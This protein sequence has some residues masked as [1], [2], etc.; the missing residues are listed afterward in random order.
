MMWA[1]LI[2]VVT[3]T[4]MVDHPSVITSYMLDQ[5][6]WAQ[7][8]SFGEVSVHDFFG[9]VFA[10][11]FHSTPCIGTNMRVTKKLLY[12]WICVHQISYFLCL[13]P[14][15]GT[16]WCPKSSRKH[17]GNMA[18]WNWN[19]YTTVVVEE[20]RVQSLCHR[21]AQKIL[22]RFKPASIDVWVFELT[23]LSEFLDVPCNSKIG[24]AWLLNLHTIVGIR[25]KDAWLQPGM[26]DVLLWRYF[27]WS[28]SALL[29]VLTV[30]WTLLINLMTAMSFFSS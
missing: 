19:N 17:W 26:S 18:G 12:R 29:P 8:M 28:F 24:V 21:I 25:I 3:S 10:I 9:L 30:Y 1:S 20:M 4:K 15:L 2:L 23:N 22:L 27:F 13:Q 14:R 11:H 5:Q 6:T 16:L 7:W